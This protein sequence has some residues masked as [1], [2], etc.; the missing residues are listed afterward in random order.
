MNLRPLAQDSPYAVPTVEAQGIPAQIPP[1][2]VVLDVRE[3]AE[4]QAGHIEGAV[5]IP[6]SVLADRVGEIHST[7]GQV[8]AVC[9]VGAR[10][11]QA[12]MF[13]RRHGHDAVNLAGGMNA[14][15]DAGRLMV[16]ETGQP[17]A[18]V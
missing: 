5:H 11:A 7:G 18:V 1:T 10:S 12:T 3:H 2:L 16:S 13:L 17:P 14:W 8:L 4:W 15:T 9:R 6:L